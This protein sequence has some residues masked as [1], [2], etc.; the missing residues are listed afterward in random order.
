MRASHE[1][2]ANKIEQDN[3]PQGQ[4]RPAMRRVKTDP[5]LGRV[6]ADPAL[7]RVKTDLAHAQ[8][9]KLLRVPTVV[10]LHFVRATML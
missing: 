7:T 3:V 8:W 6:K 5:V 4:Y 10:T 2:S 9:I 1:L